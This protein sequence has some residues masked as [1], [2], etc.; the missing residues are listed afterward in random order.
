[1]TNIV[2]LGGNGYIG[3]NVSQEW[4]SQESEA[5]L[6]IVSRS[7][8]NQLLYPQI[9][10]IKADVTNFEEVN[11]K[12]PQ[13]IDYII[14]FIGAPE[15]N[16]EKFKQINDLPAEVMLRIAKEHHVKAMGFIGGVLGDKAFVQGK[17]KIEQMLRQ[18]G[19]RLEVVSPTLVYGNGRKD[20]LSK[21]VPFLKFMGLF[22]KKFK[23][24]NVNTVAKEL[25]N[26]MRYGN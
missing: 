17:K 2:L 24:V 1:M 19:I 25:V 7:G 8:K 21:M 4:I 6:Y 9:T 13:K 18:S 14:D 12:L 26:K 22:S 5:N 10:N 23:P 16:P 11:K 15:K 3:R 20:T